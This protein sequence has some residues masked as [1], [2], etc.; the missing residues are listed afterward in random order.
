M[1]HDQQALDALDWSGTSD[2]AAALHT[3]AAMSVEQR[4]AWLEETL[5]LALATG[6]LSAERAR[7]QALADA[8]A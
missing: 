7:R 5:D 6:A 3:R 8:W 1:N 2:G 4:M